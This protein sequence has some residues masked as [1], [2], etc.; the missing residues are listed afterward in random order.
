MAVH[1]PSIERESSGRAARRGSRDSGCCR[2]CDDRPGRVREGKRD[3]F[4]SEDPLEAARFVVSD[5]VACC[6][7]GRGRCMAR[8]SSPSPAACATAEVGVSLRLDSQGRGLGERPRDLPCAC[9]LPAPVD[10]TCGARLP[11]TTWMLWTGSPRVAVTRCAAVEADSNGPRISASGTPCWWDV[12][13]GRTMRT[14]STG[15]SRIPH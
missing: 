13:P 5:A 12:W 2:D 11:A 10:P 3:Y 4:R 1:V 14:F 9:A 15:L 6:G 7:R 8:C